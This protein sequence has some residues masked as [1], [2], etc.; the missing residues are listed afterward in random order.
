[1]QFIVSQDSPINGRMVALVD[2][3]DPTC[4]KD[5]ELIKFSSVELAVEF[6]EENE[7]APCVWNVH[8]TDVDNQD[9]CK[10]CKHELEE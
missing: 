4:W 8:I 9:S 6:L 2:G 3:A 5:D 1:M 7:V 10:Y